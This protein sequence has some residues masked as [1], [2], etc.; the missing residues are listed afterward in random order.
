MKRI[1]PFIILVV[2]VLAGCQDKRVSLPW[3]EAGFQQAQ[4]QSGDKDLLIFFE[5]EW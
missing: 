1:V 3:A 4:A 2:L 5:T